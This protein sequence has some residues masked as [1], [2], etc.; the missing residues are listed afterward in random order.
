M[1]Y[2]LQPAKP[3]P[4]EFRSVA[5]SQ[6]E[7]AIQLLEEQPDGPHEAVHDARKKFKRVRALYRLVQPEAKAFRKRENARI[8]DMAQA[9]SAVRD[10]TAL[11]E[12]VDYLS[13]GAGSPEEKAALSF[14]RTILSDRRDRIAAEEHDLPAKMQSAAAACRAAIA[15]LDQ[16]DL[17]HG[18]RRTG[19][20][21]ARVWK[22]QG[23]KARAAL[24]E[25]HEN[26]HAEAFHELRKSGQT[27]WMHLALLGGI[28][29]SAMRAKQAEAKQLVDLLGHEHDLSVLTQLVDESPELFG[30]S[31]TL[32]RIL[33]AIIARQQSLRQEALPVA[34]LVFGD[35]AAI[36]ADIVARLWK[37]AARSGRKSG[38][39]KHPDRPPAPAKESAPANTSAV[40]EQRLAAE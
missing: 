13:Q 12:T 6:L 33:G 20:M 5:R 15:A 29:P 23:T 37:D 3:F 28:W 11:V 4:A 40:P 39:R 17:A 10:A 27:Y 21:L 24:R 32:A 25:C 7:K 9:L 35:E 34:A 1:A 31:E 30:D 22:T 14:A 8:R 36:E 16:L 26:A 18:P 38:K 2:R 19:A